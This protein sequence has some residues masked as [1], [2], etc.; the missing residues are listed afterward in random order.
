[1][2]RKANWLKTLPDQNL[3]QVDAG[4][5][6]FP[7][8]IIPVP[9]QK[10]SELQAKYLLKMMGNLHHDVAVP[11]EKDFALG[12]G[13]FQKLIKGSKIHFL[14]ANLLSAKGKKAILPSDVIIKSKNAAGQ[15]IT[16]GIFGLVG[17][18][19]GWPKELTV[20]P[21]VNAAKAEVAKLRE[22]ADWVIAVT[23]EGL[24]RDEAL[25]AAIPG[26]DVIV[27]GHSQSFL[28]TPVKVGQTLIIQSSFRNQYMGALPLE[29]PLASE[30]YHLVG[31]DAGYE[32]ASGKTTETD[33]MVSE[34]KS[35]I[36]DLNQKED[37]AFKKSTAKNAVKEEKF[38]TFPRCAEC[39]LK[40][41]EFWR[42]TP[43]V[44]ALHPLLA[45]NQAKNKECL[46]CHTVGF[47]DAEGFQGVSHLIALQSGSVTD[48]DWD[49][50]LN[51]IHDTNSINDT[52]P[53]KL[54]P[55]FEGA[56]IQRSLA[57]VARAWTPVQC[58]NCHSPGRDHPLTPGYSKKVDP[59]ACLTC[60]NYER[61]PDW[62]TGPKQPNMELVQ[63]KLATVRCPVGEFNSEPTPFISETSAPTPTA[64]PNE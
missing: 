46:S 63:A 18:D 30:T 49:K 6:L 58:E 4:D 16:V 48:A 53:A 9:L 37:D 24:D 40:Q 45:K 42:K 22:K 7:T 62:W 61:A 35:A 12:L 13:T 36:A 33:K 50:Y 52:I 31:L 47:G 26:I 51:L 56:T 2:A 17:E 34:F 23:H 38:Q 27:G 11:G 54:L 20:S 14:A 3:I 29:K 39:H 32:S 55:Q 10:Q 21:S 5:L 60:H 43:H 41:F 15:P 19:L 1:M 28:Q 57:K 64:T 25:A 44:L 59:N 8:D